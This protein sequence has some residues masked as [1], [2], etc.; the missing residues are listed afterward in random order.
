M[1]A[2]KKREISELTSKGATDDGPLGVIVV[3]P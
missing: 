2:P 1:G 3:D